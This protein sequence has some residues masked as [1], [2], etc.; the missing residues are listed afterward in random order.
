MAVN[1]KR[2]EFFERWFDPVAEEIL[3][4]Q[5]DIELVRLRYADAVEESWNALSTA[6]GY[7]VSA[8]TELTPP[9]FGDGVLLARCPLPAPADDVV[10]R[11]GV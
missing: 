6:C 10:H 8:R 2:L 3:S 7:Q 4:A 1:R 11:R 5:E 9:W